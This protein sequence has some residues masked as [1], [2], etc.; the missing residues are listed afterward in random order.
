MNAVILWIEGG[1]WSPDSW[2]VEKH[3]KKSADGRIIVDRVYEWISID[4]SDNIFNYYEQAEIDGISS[5]LVDARPCMIQWRGTSIADE[6]FGS[7]PDGISAIIDNDHGL[8]CHVD[9]VKKLSVDF[10]AYRKEL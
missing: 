2:F 5:N 4:H 8:V 10:W 6:F 3:G 1:A 7:I 9:R